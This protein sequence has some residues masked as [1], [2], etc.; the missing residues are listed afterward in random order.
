MQDDDLKQDVKNPIKAFDETAKVN[1][2]PSVRRST[3]PEFLRRYRAWLFQAYI[4]VS[5]LVFVA[6]AVIVSTAT[7]YLNIDLRL[8]REIQNILPPWAGSILAW[9]S[10]IGFPPQS[11]IMT[12][13]IVIVVYLLGLR[14]EAVTVMLAAAASIAINTL[15]KLAIRRP[16]PSANM[17]EVV[18]VLNSYSFP[19]GHTMFY[20]AF[21]GFLAFLTFT[22]MKNYWLRA[23][24]LTLFIGLVVLIGPS[25]IYLGEHWGSDV[26]AAYVLGFLILA[27]VIWTYRWGKPRY[28]VR[29]P[30]APGAESPPE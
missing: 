17:V 5:L 18:Q 11:V 14:W 20:T 8:T 23:A 29:Q 13:V 15:V 28:F 26:L 16:R 30:V 1:I 22:L 25:R 27:G 3:V 9:I 7:T 24:L 12:V 10:W 4:L 19:S 21:F 6:L 2:Y